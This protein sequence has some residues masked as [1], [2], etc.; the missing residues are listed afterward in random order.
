MSRS[1]LE[2]CA[3]VLIDEE[4]LSVRV[5]DLSSESME[6]IRG[7]R[8]V[9]DQIILVGLEVLG[10]CPVGLEV[11]EV[12]AEVLK[13]SVHIGVHVGSPSFLLV[14]GKVQNYVRE[15]SP[16]LLRSHHKLIYYLLGVV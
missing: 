2:D 7:S 3:F 13:D 4:R 5:L 10:I 9:V 16:L 6:V 1:G 8:E 12:I 14:V 11:S 15:T